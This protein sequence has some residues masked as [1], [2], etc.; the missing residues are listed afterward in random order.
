MTDLVIDLRC[1]SCNA[2]VVGRQD[3]DI[4]AKVPRVREC[5]K[6]KKPVRMT[7][8]DVGEMS[9]YYVEARP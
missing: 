9:D 7:Q 3:V 8:S 6:C 2:P 1:P 5:R 4:L